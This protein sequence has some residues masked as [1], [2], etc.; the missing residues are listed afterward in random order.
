MTDYLRTL[1]LN[2]P[3]YEGFDGG[4]GSRYQ[5]R[6]EVR[7]F[8]YPTWLAQPAGAGA[9]HPA[10][11]RA[12][13][14]PHA[15]RRASAR[16][17]TTTSSSCTPA[18]R[19]S[20]PT[21][22]AEALK[23]ANPGLSIG[24]VG[25][26]STV[27]ARGVAARGPAVDFVAREEF[28]LTRGGDRRGP[29]ARATSPGSPTA[30]DGAS[31]H[32]AERPVLE[33]LDALPFVDAVYARDL[34]VEKYDIGYLQHPYVSLYTGRGCRAGCTFCLWPQTIGGHSYRTRSVENVLREEMAQPR[35]SF[36]EVREFFFDD[37]TFT[38]DRP[39]AEAIARGSASS[40]SP[41]RCNAQGERR[42][43]RR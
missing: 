14:R 39:R 8:W 10:D 13:R 12:A 37:D 40:A 26:A 5:A 38:D 42:R 20:P 43:T 31:P 11:R 23:A 29:A 33:D 34:D 6:R 19:R 24:F 17:A 32:A 16:R 35:G 22:T 36:P 3:S 4:A 21:W 9:G 2:P 1:F 41:G 30:H 15:R 25:A 7:S 27:R 28:D 18:R